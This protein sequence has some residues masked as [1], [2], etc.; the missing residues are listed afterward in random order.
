MFLLCCVVLV[1]TFFAYKKV[2]IH[3]EEDGSISPS[4]LDYTAID[5]MPPQKLE[6]ELEIS[7]ETRKP[8]SLFS[9]NAFI[10]EEIDEDKTKNKK[11]AS[12]DEAKIDAFSSGVIKAYF[13]VMPSDITSL[14]TAELQSG[15]YGI[16]SDFAGSFGSIPNEN[17]NILIQSS[18]QVPA[19][20]SPQNRE[21]SIRT[22]DETFGQIGILM[23]VTVNEISEASVM[24][25]SNIEIALLEG[26]EANARRIEN[27]QTFD[28][29]SLNRGN[30]AFIFALLPH[31]P[32]SDI[33]RTLLPPLLV[34]V[35]GI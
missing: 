31:R 27:L 1:T 23:E 17:K 33:E 3:F 13:L 26:V 32:P 22:E 10:S 11:D 25:Q 6:E 8:P 24:L 2:L 30:A 12:E 19:S 4:N 29:I 9:Q 5:S 7:Q 28:Q 16:I 15:Q 35:T 20:P 14:Q 21:F 34:S 18:W